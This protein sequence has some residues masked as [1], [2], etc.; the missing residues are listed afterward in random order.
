MSHSPS[1]TPFFS[2]SQGLGNGNFNNPL[3]FSQG[4]SGLSY[5]NHFTGTFEEDAKPATSRF[6]PIN[7]LPDGIHG[8]PFN[9]Y[10]MPNGGNFY[11]GSA[12]QTDT[13]NF[14]I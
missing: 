2:H 4:A 5:T 6:Q 1:P 12:T 13:P 7:T 11:T 3:A 8:L 14:E 10:A 9:A